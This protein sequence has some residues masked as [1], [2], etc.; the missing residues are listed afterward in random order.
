MI[1]EAG[2]VRDRGKHVRERDN[3]MK[4]ICPM[5]RKEIVVASTA[6]WLKKERETEARWVVD[7][8]EINRSKNK[9]SAVGEG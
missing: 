6:I 1:K 4:E 9:D 5:E 3:E 2:R 7:L 8:N